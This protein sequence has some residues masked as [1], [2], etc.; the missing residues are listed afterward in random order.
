MALMGS[1]GSGVTA[2]QSF[3]KGM[4]VI[5][6]NIANSKTVGF[7]R[8]RVNYADNFSDT[9]RDAAPG[10]NS[11]SNT[12]PIQFGSGVNVGAAQ[13]IHQQ[14]SIELTGIASDLAISGDGFF[15]VLD[16][17][18]GNQFLTRDGS[19]RLDE[20]GYMVDKNGFYL[21]GLTGGNGTEAP[22]TIER[23]RIDLARNVKVNNQDQPLDAAG[24]IVLEDGS[25][26]QAS[27][28]GSG[29][30]F[31]V[32]ANGRLL[33][34][35]KDGFIPVTV[36]GNPAFA[37]LNTSDDAYYLINEAGNYI[38]AT[39]AEV[40]PATPF[41]ATVSASAI[42]TAWDPGIHRSSVYGDRVSVNVNTAT[43]PQTF[44]A[45]FNSADNDYYLVNSAGNYVDAN[46]TELL[47]DHDGDALTP[48]I[49]ESFVSNA[50]PNVAA[51]V[52]W[53]PA[54]HIANSLSNNIILNDIGGSQV[55]ARF[56]TVD[57]AY[58]LINSDGNYIT[59]TGAEILDGGGL[60]VAFDPTLSTAGLG[61]TS[62]AVAWDP[63]TETQA[64]PDN[65]VLRSLGGAA[66]RAVFDPADGQFYLRNTAGQFI[67]GNGAVTTA[68]VVWDPSTQPLAKPGDDE[69][70]VAKWDP[71]VAAS[72]ANDAI[73]GVAAV[74]STD[75]NQF[76]LAIQSWAFNKE[77]NLTLSLNDGS[78][79]TRAKVMLQTVADPNALS[80]EGNGLFSGY[81]NAGVIGLSEWNLGT[82]LSTA[83]SR[84]HL[85]NE[86]GLGFIQ[87]RALESSNTDLTAEFSDMITTQRA[88]Q[89]G[90][91]V[92]TVSDEM[93]QEII[94]L[95][96]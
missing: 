32:D 21:L 36:N 20:N 54:E 73:P 2:M 35:A 41:N 27:T 42:A 1:L 92:I 43:G 28:D 86:N 58:Y 56:N 13:K 19:F 80:V 82:Q 23:I 76:Q 8:Q 3:V 37:A 30:S 48:D 64:P 81:Q 49:P 31:R 45:A 79:Y 10:S 68:P 44:S 16:A 50:S 14:G 34:T 78:S 88:F 95:K 93:L 38:D 24:R 61:L 89:A 74:D 17:G 40:S 9:L 83:D 87:G 71:V 46:G 47:W 55:T 18:S 59:A 53:D 65:L 26:I 66:A 94:N 15:R 62:P 67:D 22:D 69:A 90:S 4:E 29:D 12:T 11:S 91:R 96:R 85:A 7:K 25:R 75:P 70:N 84:F 72:G 33:A 77:G 63:S 60:S 5:G 6:D 39:G 51:P 52:S 57:N